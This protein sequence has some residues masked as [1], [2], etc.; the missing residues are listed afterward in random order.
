MGKEIKISYKKNGSVEH[1]LAVYNRWSSFHLTSTQHFRSGC[2]QNSIANWRERI[3]HVISN[4]SGDIPDSRR[5]TVTNAVSVASSETPPWNKEGQDSQELSNICNTKW[6]LKWKKAGNLGIT[7]TLRRLLKRLPD[8][9]KHP[10][11]GFWYFV[12]QSWVCLSSS[13]SIKI[14]GRAWANERSTKAVNLWGKKDTINIL[15]KTKKGDRMAISNNWTISRALI[16][17]K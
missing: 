9:L 15:A 17:R 16:G 4:T 5:D 6:N 1:E 11:C 13:R 7:P 10:S 2:T 12:I 14:N 3:K 8:F